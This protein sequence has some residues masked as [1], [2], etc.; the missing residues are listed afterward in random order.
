MIRA[1]KLH[2]TVHTHMSAC[3]AR[4]TWIRL[5]CPFLGGGCRGASCQPGAKP[6]RRTSD[7]S[8]LFGSNQRLGRSAHFQSSKS[9]EIGTWQHS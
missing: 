1:V 9:G 8:S 2:P 5:V 3:G 4:E 6:V 7:L